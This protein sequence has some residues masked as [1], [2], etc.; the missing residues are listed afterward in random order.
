MATVNQVPVLPYGIG[1]ITRGWATAAVLL[2]AIFVVGAVAYSRQFIEGEEV[3]G[4]RDVGTMGGAPWGL[5]VVFVIYFIG[6]STGLMLIGVTA[7]LLRIEKLRSTTRI[8]EGLAIISLILGALSVVSDLG[9]PLR[10]IVNFFR[11][12]HPMSPFFGTFTLVVAGALFAS[13]VYLFLTLRPDAAVL[14]KQ[15]SGLAW[16]YRWW[17]SGYGDS[18]AERDRRERSSVWLALGILPL[19]ILAYSTLGFVFGLQVGRPGWQSAL[20]APGFIILAVVSGAAL[21]IIVAAAARRMPGAR[22]ELSLPVFKWLS[23]L[24]TILLIVYLY[25]LLAELLT[26]GYTSTEAGW[27]VTRSLLVGSFAWLNWISVSMLVLAIVMGVWQMANR[28][29]NIPMIVISG[30]L[31][32]IIAVL[33]R[34][35]IVVPSLTKGALLPYEE[36]SYSPTII[37]Y[38]VILGLIAL[39]ALMFLAFMKLV[40]IVELKKEEE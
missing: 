33:Q 30:I 16:F 31:V 4:L 24:M 38:G 15:K 19:R 20:Q 3:T 8:A 25:F 27:R 36:G 10:G 26:T 22:E 34:Y 23:N 7:E 5:Y 17:A 28:S 21:L 18:S 1:R 2:L 32:T 12:A 6:V 35:L 29:Y 11:Y 13:L 37:E 40:P 39:G 14:A 9:Q